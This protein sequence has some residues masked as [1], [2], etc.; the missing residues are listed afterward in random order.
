MSKYY[1]VIDI[2]KNR[3]DA[4]DRSNPTCRDE[5]PRSTHRTVAPVSPAG[6]SASSNAE[7][8]ILDSFLSHMRQK[9]GESGDE[10]SA[11][12]SGHFEPILEISSESLLKIGSFAP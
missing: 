7:H 6:E 5:N 2:S 1:Y 11:N 4:L 8:C 9:T 3:V 12:F 10:F